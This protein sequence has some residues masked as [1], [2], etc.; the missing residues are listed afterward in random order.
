[1]EF[2]VSFWLF[3][4]RGKGSV[5]GMQII[6]EVFAPIQSKKATKIYKVMLRSR[7]CYESGM[8]SRVRAENQVE[9]WDAK[10][11]GLE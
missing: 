8:S 7:T 6:P 2:K 5:D 1:M 4:I 3:D 9:M 10:A 11:S